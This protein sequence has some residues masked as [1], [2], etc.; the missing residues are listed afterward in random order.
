MA[1]N[2]LKGTSDFSDTEIKLMK[3]AQLEKIGE[4]AR[5]GG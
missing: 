4:K 5:Y 3:Q 1:L 2:L